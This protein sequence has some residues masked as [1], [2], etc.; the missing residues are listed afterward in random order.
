M[1]RYLVQPLVLLCPYGHLI[2]KPQVHLVVP[3]VLRHLD[4]RYIL[5]DPSIRTK[6]K[7]IT[8]PK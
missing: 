7:F 2:L 1:R 4:G 6:H 3:V 5:D 8:F